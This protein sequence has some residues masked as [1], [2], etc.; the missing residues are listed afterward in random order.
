MAL[1]IP[2]TLLILGRLN[3]LDADRFPME[4]FFDYHF[5]SW[6]AHLHFCDFAAVGREI[7]CDCSDDCMKYKT[8]C[9]DKLWDKKKNENL[10]MYLK[11]F[12][13]KSQKYK[14][15]SCEPA[16]TVNKTHAVKSYFMV[17]SCLPNT[18]G[19]DVERCLQPG[20]HIKDD[21]PVL[22]NDTYLYRNLHC[23][24][25][26]LVFDYKFIDI[27]A[28][29][30]NA[31][32]LML[33]KTISKEELNKLSKCEFSLD[34]SDHFQQ[35]YI[36]ACER[37]QNVC[38]Q[39]DPFYNLC[40]AYG[41]T[42]GEYKN[43]D[44]AMCAANQNFEVIVINRTVVQ[45]THFHN[46]THHVT[47]LKNVTIQEAYPVTLPMPDIDFTCSAA[48]C[49]SR[50]CYLPNGEDS[51]KFESTF[52]IGAL[53]ENKGEI[54]YLKQKFP[55]RQ[56]M[57][58]SKAYDFGF[59]K[60]LEQ[61]LC[62]APREKCCDCSDDCMVRKR[63]C[64]D[65][66][67]NETH[68]VNLNSYINQFIQTSQG[69]KDH[70]CEPV[71]PMAFSFTYNVEHQLMVKSC[72]LKANVDNAKKCIH[73]AQKGS[74]DSNLPVTSF[75]GYIY[76][77]SFCAKC[78][79]ITKYQPI[80]VKV[81]CK[82]HQNFANMFHN[83]S[84]F[85]FQEC[86]FSLANSS[87]YK[88]KKCNHWVSSKRN[89]PRSSIHYELCHAYSGRVGGFQNYHCWLCSQ[90]N[91]T[92]AFPPIEYC[93][94]T[95]C[96]IGQ[97]NCYEKPYR[98]WSL[99]LN[100]NT[101][102]FQIGNQESRSIC[103]NGSKY[104]TG[105]L[106]CEKVICPPD[107][108]FDGK[109][110]LPK[111]KKPIP[112][113]HV[114]KPTF[115]KCFSSNVTLYMVLKKVISSSKIKILRNFPPY[116]YD[117]FTTY[118]V[119]NQTNDDQFVIIL[120]NFLLPPWSDV[121]QNIY[122]FFK[123]SKVGYNYN[124]W[125]NI[126]KILI[127]KGRKLKYTEHYQLEMSRYFPKNRICA[128]A[129]IRNGTDGSF[130]RSCMVTKG[131][132]TF[133]KHNISMWIEISRNSSSKWYSTCRKYHLHSNCPRRKISGQISFSEEGNLL[134][135]R[136][137][138]IDTYNVS[139]YIPLSKGYGV[140]IRSSFTGYGVKGNRL[141]TVYVIEHYISLIGTIIS[142]IFY[143]F[144][145]LSFLIFKELRTVPGLNTLGMCISLFIAEVIF[146]L[147][148][149]SNFSGTACKIVAATLHWC[150]LISFM[151]NLIIAFDLISKFSSFT[152]ASRGNNNKKF[153]RRCIYSLIPPTLI[154]SLSVILA[155][156]TTVV[157][158]GTKGICW[159]T[160]FYARIGFYI[161]PVAVIFFTTLLTL[162]YTV[163]KIHS[164]FKVN[165]EVLKTGKKSKKET[166]K[167]ALKLGII[168]GVTEG[169]G[170]IQ[171]VKSHPSYNE[172]V[173]NACF[174]L[175]YSTFRSI[176]GLMLCLVYII[177]ANVL[178][179]YR[180]RA[181]SLF[182]TDTGRNY[183]FIYRHKGMSTSSGQ[184]DK[185]ETNTSTV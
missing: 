106:K 10:E 36:R 131:N 64:I 154:V 84:V 138:Q 79:S 103:R 117:K 127:T 185:C 124:L 150:I 49:K 157:D 170:F 153:I 55:I 128:E 5:D 30:E 110:C 140:C 20:F 65:K 156:E 109:D 4:E 179:L 146:L 92:V 48:P 27:K 75:D 70:S 81:N 95:R 2:L 22:G 176:R 35:R 32:N 33:R 173:F 15:M 41:E 19:D 151:W 66:F 25:C 104:D 171:I 60:G 62:N 177:G 130:T 13:S 56:F 83:T 18:T 6:G 11:L 112:E 120:S 16:L 118:S 169:L 114:L 175:L 57:N 142:I 58:I 91:Q 123:S 155:A 99:L 101:N 135:K 108:V 94:S 14:N 3:F 98:P 116:M 139:E 184:H 132:E 17:K 86:D 152:V 24:K 172:E 149:N 174:S 145:I 180:K 168:L 72:L 159:I 82:N 136:L 167:I 97:S 182:T 178:A 52:S 54:K 100:F 87:Y 77:N 88:S 68:P 37:K 46:G 34:T 50:H 29:C 107:F 40:N 161:I 44:C 111:P 76:R 148:I 12:L 105:T 113:T 21:I 158:Y 141:E 43:Y 181:R 129:N 59:N 89:C 31:S 74:L 143:I 69:Y 78:N 71:L 125:H 90:N 144:V 119:I 23:A 39:T 85:S 1:F 53:E 162:L 73:G 26:N 47:T 38:P 28:K 67:W 80:S 63:C 96:P 42:M 134:H 160:G 93:D 126:E 45:P 163:R 7:C 137:G 9:I 166:L 51:T 61:Y 115:D 122:K 165:E 147:A 102:Q 133:S 8:C 164:E 121:N 183:N